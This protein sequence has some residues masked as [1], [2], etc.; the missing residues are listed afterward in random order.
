MPCREQSQGLLCLPGTAISHLGG[1]MKKALLSYLSG[2]CQAASAALLAGAVLMPGIREAAVCSAA[3]AALI[4][5][6][7]V[8]LRERRG[9]A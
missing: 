4:G 7:L 3:V 2:L 1:G 9:A 6:V 8:I 5:A